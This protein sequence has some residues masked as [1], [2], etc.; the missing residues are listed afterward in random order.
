[1]LGSAGWSPLMTKLIERVVKQ[2]TNDVARHA[3]LHQALHVVRNILQ[4]D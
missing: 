2:R 4:R 1:M 3:D